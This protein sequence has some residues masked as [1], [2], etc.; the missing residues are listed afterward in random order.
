MRFHEGQ[1]VEVTAGETLDHND[2]PMGAA[3]LTGRLDGDS[4]V[5]KVTGKKHHCIKL[6]E[7][8]GGGM[9]SVAEDQMRTGRRSSVGH[10]RRFSQRY[11]EIFG[12]KHGLN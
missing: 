9:A 8:S 2:E 1:E 11:D 6:D 5:S 10:S 3:G 7:E 12:S 4:Y